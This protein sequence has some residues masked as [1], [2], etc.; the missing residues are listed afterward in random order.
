VGPLEVLHLYILACLAQP[1]GQ[2]GKHVSGANPS[3]KSSYSRIVGSPSFFIRIRLDYE[4]TAPLPNITFSLPRTYAGNVSVNRTGHPDDSLFFVA[5]EKEGGSLGAA[6][7]ERA[8]EPWTIWLN[9]GCVILLTSKLRL[10]F[11]QTRIIEHVRS[12]H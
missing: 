2:T 10:S 6:D 9:G 7:G 4:V 1:T 12:V 8:D 3:P 11:S 5:F